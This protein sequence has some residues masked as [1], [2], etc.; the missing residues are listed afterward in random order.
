MK[1]SD[2]CSTD[3]RLG[4]YLNTMVADLQID[5]KGQYLRDLFS[6]FYSEVCAAEAGYKLAKQLTSQQCMQLCRSCVY[7]FGCED[8]SSNKVNCSSYTVAA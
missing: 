8:Y 3:G 7:L 4:A 2:M 6:K 5:G 1:I